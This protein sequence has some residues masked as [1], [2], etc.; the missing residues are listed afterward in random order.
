[1]SLF[2]F[3]TDISL[4]TIPESLQGWCQE[5]VLGFL[6]VGVSLEQGLGVAAGFFDQPDVQ[7]VSHMQLVEAGLARAQE[8]PGTALLQVFLG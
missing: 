6:E 5:L 8:L 4:S 7:Q 3:L 2:S 1:M